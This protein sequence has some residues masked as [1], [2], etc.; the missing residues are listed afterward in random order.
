MRHALRVLLAAAF[1]FCSSSAAIADEVGGVGT[2][3]GL[4]VNTDDG[5]T[6]LGYH[7]RLILKN[8]D[9]TLQEYRWGGI[10]CGSRQLS[11]PQVIT[12]QGALDNNKMRVQPLYQLGQG[13][14]R[15]LVGFTIVPKSALKLVFP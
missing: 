12:L 10:S 9:G 1:L 2:P 13:D 8:A 7:G 11:E 15:C 6:Y 5:D 3:V 14:A 4:S